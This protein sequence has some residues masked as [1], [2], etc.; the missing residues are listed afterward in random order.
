MI[1]KFE[2]EQANENNPK[3]DNM[4]K[5]EKKIYKRKNDLRSEFE[6]DYTRIIHCTAYRRL[7]HKTQVFYSPENDHICTRIEHVAHVESIS[8][9]IAK[10]LGLNQELTRAIAIGHDIGHSPFGHEGEKILNSLSTEEIGEKF[11]HEK[12]GLDMVDNIE[13]LEDTMK[14]KQNL[15]LTYAVRDGIISHCGEIDENCLKPREEFIDLKEYQYPNQFS[16]YTWEGCIVKIA[17]KISYLGRDIEDAI[18]VGILDEKLLSLYELL[19][20]DSS[21]NVINNTVIINDLITDLCENSSLEKGLCF[22]ASRYDCFGDKE[23]YKIG[24]ETIK[25]LLPKVENRLQPDRRVASSFDWNNI[26]ENIMLPMPYVI[27]LTKRCDNDHMWEN[28]AD[29]GHGVVL[30]LDETKEVSFESM[31]HM[32][33]LKPCIYKGKESDEELFQEIETE[34][35]NGAFGMLAGPKKNLYLDC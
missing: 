28:Y 26:K 24:I 12:N 27:S 5:R 23:E 17:D 13:L 10:Y 9:T 34:Y 31:P 2:N 15:N 14:N 1:K 32:I 7:K 11:W 4:I 3:W 33:M 6:R 19:N 25:A 22:W 16:P 30:A 20:L 21:K 8:Y 35:F 18:S 29:H